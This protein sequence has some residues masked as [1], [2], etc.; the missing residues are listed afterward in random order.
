MR[1]D[2]DRAKCRLDLALSPPPLQRLRQELE[3]LQGRGE[4]LDSFRVGRAL[5]GSLPR[6]LPIIDGLLMNPASV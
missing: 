2:V 1:G 5:D 4:V 6:F 3:Q